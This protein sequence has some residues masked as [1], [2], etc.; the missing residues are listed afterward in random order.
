M[1]KAR[2]SLLARLGVGFSALRAR[3]DG[4]PGAPFFSGPVVRTERL[5]LRPGKQRDF[6]RWREARLRSMP[7]L[8]PWEPAWSADHLS[9]TAF[10]RRVAWSDAEIRAGRAYPLLIFRDGR[11]GGDLV[12]GVTVEHVRRGAAQSA[13]LGY[14]LSTEHTGRVY[15]TEALEGLIS[16]AFDELDLS[17]LE[18]ACV[19]H[20]FRSRKVLERVG[21]HVEGLARSYLQID[22]EWRDHI[23]Y[24]RRRRDR[25]G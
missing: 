21:F 3:P 22:G 5:T 14:W 18:A 24:E 15:M 8:V 6:E 12:G 25:L 13:A 20:N 19:A 23:L 9:V 7:H 4:R 1:K 10:R 16:Y 17:R 2:R 11:G